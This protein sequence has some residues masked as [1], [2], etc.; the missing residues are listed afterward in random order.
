M[1]ITLARTFIA[2][3]DLG[4]FLKASE[5][6]YVTQSTVSSRVRL[7]EDL[8]GQV[9][10]VRT[11]A[12]ANLTPAGNQFKPFAEKLVQT[13]EQ[14]RQRVGLPEDFRS[15]FSVGVE[16]TLWERL[17][18]HWI[19]WIRSAIPDMAIRTDVG[20]SAYLV[21]QMVDGLL[22][23]VVTYTPQQ[24]PGLV[25]EHLM[26]E[27]LVFVSSDPKTNG[28]WEPGYIYV[29]W[30]PEFGI[31][32]MDAFP[33]NDAPVVAVTYG[34]LALQQIILHGG[35][36]YLPMRLVR[37]RL[38]DGSL[39]Q[40]DKMPSFMRPVYSIYLQDEESERFKTAIQGLR[41]VAMAES[42]DQ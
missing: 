33:H 29:D 38:E 31:E 7:L 11:K 15:M 27:E 9:L 2:I 8:L 14:A 3:C 32:H 5:R 30:G 21:R 25:I 39:Y 41:Y 37:P 16:F 10:F 13:W 34:P 6:L 40:I 35:A 42:E 22:D 24:R 28:P 4:N 1:D 23:L 36:A 20:S 26:D 17:L 18:V 19:P 12:G